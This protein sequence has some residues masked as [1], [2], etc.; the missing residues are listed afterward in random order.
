MRC[1]IGLKHRQYALNCALSQLFGVSGRLKSIEPV[2]VLAGVHDAYES[3]DHSPL[4]DDEQD[5]FTDTSMVFA[6]D[7]LWVRVVVGGRERVQV[8][9]YGEMYCRAGTFFYPLVLEAR[10]GDM[11]KTTAKIIKKHGMMRVTMAPTLCFCAGGG[12]R[13]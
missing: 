1:R 9:K 13:I 5:L 6:N 3:P 2:G 7:R 11:S 4:T 10:S 8:N 12:C